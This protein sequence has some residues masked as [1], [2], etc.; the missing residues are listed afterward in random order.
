MM[1]RKLEVLML[2]ASRIAEWVY[3][4]AI[5]CAALFGCDRRGRD[6]TTD[7]KVLSG[8]DAGRVVEQDPKQA[9]P[10]EAREVW[11]E[12]PPYE[13]APSLIQ[14][15]GHPSHY[16]GKKVQVQGYLV[17]EFEGTAIYLSKDDEYYLNSANGFW[18]SLKD[19]ILRLSEQDIAKK[20]NRRYVLLEGTFDQT[21]YGHMRQFSGTFGKI[22]RI[23]R[24]GR[25]QLVETPKLEQ[26]QG[27]SR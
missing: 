2:P 9:T 14:I 20:Y 11:L 5:V 15:L 13:R 23:Q 27:T 12:A 6:D 24:A 1:N 4:S 10:S 18:V 22:S 7:A 17:V 19:N 16:H 25:P 8:N 26:P 3:F 21:D